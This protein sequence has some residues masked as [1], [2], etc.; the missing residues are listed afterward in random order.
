MYLYKNIHKLIRDKMTRKLLIHLNLFKGAC[1]VRDFKDEDET[2]E[3]GLWVLGSQT[4]SIP[5]IQ[6]LHYNRKKGCTKDAM[7]WAALNG[8]L[9]LM[10]WF[11]THRTEGFT[12]LAIQYATIQGHTNVVEWLKEN[13]GKSI[14]A[15]EYLDMIS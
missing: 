8:Y 10:K 11:H 2:L 6:Y 15:S 3:Y 4:G 7:N 5:F 1:E 14:Q 13:I 12:N 9:D